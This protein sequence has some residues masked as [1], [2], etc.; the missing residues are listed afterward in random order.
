MPSF[1]YWHLFHSSLSWG[2]KSQG[3]S[4][5][6][7]KISVSEMTVEVGISLIVLDAIL[8][9]LKVSPYNRDSV[10]GFLAFGKFA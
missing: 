1:L 10:T 9:N 3:N 4:A 5:T 7:K 6:G 8:R 2:I